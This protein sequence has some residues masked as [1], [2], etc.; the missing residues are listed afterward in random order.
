MEKKNRGRVFRP[1]LSIKYL[2][3][4]DASGVVRDSCSGAAVATFIVRKTPAEINE[5][6]FINHVRIEPWG[7]LD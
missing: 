6:D 3:T 5:S 4:I 7:E 2:E 1:R